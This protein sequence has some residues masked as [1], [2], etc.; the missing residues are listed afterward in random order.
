MRSRGF[1]I[2]DVL[3][4]LFLLVVLTLLLAPVYVHP[5]GRSNR[6]KCSNNLRQLGLAAVQY[7]DDKRFLPHVRATKELDGAITSSDTARSVRALV[8]YGYHDNPEG[9]ICP[10]SADLHVPVAD[11]E[12]LDNMRLWGWQGSFGEPGS[13]RNTTP[14]WRD[15]GAGGDQALLETTELSYAYTRRGYNRNVSSL[16]ILMAD[17]SLRPREVETTDLTPGNLGNH[18]DGW[19]VLRA[20]CTVSFVN[21]DE[22]LLP[23]QGAHATLSGTESR[24][25]GHLPLG[26]PERPDP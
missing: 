2:F 9:F 4:V 1:S 16:K 21:W 13:A 10:S 6:V 8:W 7:G 11:A 18:R 26:A 17:R 19:N 25:Q 12:V 23:G 22:E 5:H 24:E 15:E 20:D 14:P 3:V